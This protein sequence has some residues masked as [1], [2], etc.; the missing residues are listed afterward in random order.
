MS[1]QLAS[2]DGNRGVPRRGGLGASASF[3]CAHGCK[4]PVAGL[5]HC[6]QSGKGMLGG[7]KASAK[8]DFRDRFS[9]FIVPQVGDVVKM[10]SKWPGEWDVG[11]VDRAVRWAARG[12]QEST[13]SSS[14]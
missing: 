7:E 10:P 9:G 12:M 14:S 3:H 6:G 5:V 4:R 8:L 2:H 13:S 11:Q 1:L